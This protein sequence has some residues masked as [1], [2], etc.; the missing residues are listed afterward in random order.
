M[1]VGSLN[2]SVMAWLAVVLRS[3]RWATKPGQSTRIL[4]VAVLLAALLAAPLVLAD[5]SPTSSGS[6]QLASPRDSEALADKLFEQREYQRAGECY[7]TAG[8]SSRAQLA[9]L[10]A[11]GPNGEAAARGLKEER[12]AAKHLAMRVAQAFHRDH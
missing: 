10:K 2:M 12:G 3:P 7:E 8:N 11:V 1:E 5:P 9:Y 4:A 6:C